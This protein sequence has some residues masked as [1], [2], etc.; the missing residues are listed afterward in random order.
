MATSI[1]NSETPVEIAVR[2]DVEVHD[3]EDL[4]PLTSATAVGRETSSSQDSSSNM[5]LPR[6]DYDPRRVCL[7]PFPEFRWLDS[8]HRRIAGVYI[9]GALVRFLTFLINHLRIF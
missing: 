2:V 1:A 3:D 6:A 7:N 5:S 4:G 8:K 9:A